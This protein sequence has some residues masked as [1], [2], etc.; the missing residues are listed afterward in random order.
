MGNKTLYLNLNRF[1]EKIMVARLDGS[2]IKL[3]NQ[4]EK[5]KLLLLD[6]F[7]LAPFDQNSRLAL[8]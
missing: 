1:T 2:F 4:L 6:D 5:V 3:L 8:L 7:A